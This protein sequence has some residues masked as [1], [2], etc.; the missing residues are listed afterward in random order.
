MVL[1][2]KFKNATA[3]TFKNLV[4]KTMFVLDI[5]KSIVSLNYIIFYSK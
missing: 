4:R 5:L 1:Q 3:K 2:N